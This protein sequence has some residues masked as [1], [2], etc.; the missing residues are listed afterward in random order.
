MKPPGHYAASFCS[1]PGHSNQPKVADAK[2]RD[3][4]ETQSQTTRVVQA[5]PP[6]K[7][8]RLG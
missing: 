2:V 3:G 7:D 6:G 1:L 5:G 4:R 8:Y